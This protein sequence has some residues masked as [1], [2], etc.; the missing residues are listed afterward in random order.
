M[1]KAVAIYDSYPVEKKLDELF[2]SEKPEAKMRG[3]SQALSGE[4]NGD[5][6]ERA[7]AWFQN[8]TWTEEQK[9][10]TKFPRLHALFMGHAA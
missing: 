8:L 5:R 3:L 10:A 7:K 2:S 1:Y 4:E 9:F 6:R